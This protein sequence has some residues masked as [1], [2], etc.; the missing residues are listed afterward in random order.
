MDG[1]LL[2]GGI[3]AGIAVAVGSL[4]LLLVVIYWSTRNRGP[5]RPV[6]LDRHRE[7]LRNFRLRYAAE[8]LPKRWWA[9]H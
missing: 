8:P 1:T 3:A 7:A 9:R 6:D 2:R 4:L 5:R